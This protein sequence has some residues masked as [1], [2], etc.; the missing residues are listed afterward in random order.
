MTFILFV[1]YVAGVDCDL[2]VRCVE[3]TDI[4]D[5]QMSQYL[6][7]TISLKKEL[8]SKLKHKTPS[9]SPS[10]VVAPAT[11]AVEQSPAKVEVTVTSTVA[12]PIAVTTVSNSSSGNKEVISH[13]ESLIA[14]LA[15]SLEA[16]FSVVDSHFSQV[17]VSSAS[18]DDIA[19]NVSCQDVSNP[20]I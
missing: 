5:D 16:R 8:E 9:Q 11:A 13:V 18:T 10:A 20:S 1:Y 12:A 19:K 4:S 6:T 7:H 14:S 17:L 3:C 15:Q 2:T